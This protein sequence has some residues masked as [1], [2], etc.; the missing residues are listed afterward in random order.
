MKFDIRVIIVFLNTLKNFCNLNVLDY[1]LIKNYNK[2]F[3]AY[4]I[5]NNLISKDFTKIN[6]KNNLIY[7]KYDFT[8]KR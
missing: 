3:I 4:N 7:L 6:K 8:K 2:K 1:F 5:I